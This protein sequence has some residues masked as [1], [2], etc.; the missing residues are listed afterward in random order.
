[1]DEVYFLR[2]IMLPQ[3]EPVYSLDL[4]P[5][6]CTPHSNRLGKILAFEE[7]SNFL[8]QAIRD[9]GSPVSIT[10]QEKKKSNRVWRAAVVSLFEVGLGIW[11]SGAVT[12]G[13][14]GFQQFM[15]DLGEF[16]NVK[17]GNVS[18]VVLGMSYRKKGRTPFLRSLIDVT[19]RTFEEKDL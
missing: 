12:Q 3:Q 1:M 11:K 16:F 15:L 2:R 17:V 6:F 10:A 5:T 7:L 19:E 4:D 8:N 9:V 13:P 14:G 18:R